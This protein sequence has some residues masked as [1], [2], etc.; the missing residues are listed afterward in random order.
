MLLNILILGITKLPIYSTMKML[1][2]PKYLVGPLLAL[3]IICSVTYLGN[4]VLHEDSFVEV[5]L[6]TGVTK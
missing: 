5:N 1:M 4:T 2:L 3:A 6:Q